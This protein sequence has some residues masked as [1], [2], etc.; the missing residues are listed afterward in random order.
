MGRSRGVYRA[1]VDD[2]HDPLSRCRLR[3]TVPDAGGVSAWAEACL[4]PVP[5]GLLAMPEVGCLVWVQFEDGD[6]QRPVWTGVAWDTAQLAEVVV[7]SPAS[8][9]VRAPVVTI[10]AGSTELT[11]VVT[12]QTLIAEAVI[13]S[14][15]APGAGD[16][17]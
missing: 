2:A 12:C 17:T 9:K 14:S 15:Y 11:G 1:V 3:V 7:T 13:A 16:L 6:R 10:E 5:A 4:P 8:V